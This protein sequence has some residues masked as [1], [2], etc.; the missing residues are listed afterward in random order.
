MTRDVKWWEPR[1]GLAQVRGTHQLNIMDKHTRVV[2]IFEGV[3]ALVG[4]GW[5]YKTKD[6]WFATPWSRSDK[7]GFWMG[8]EEGPFKTKAQA[9]AALG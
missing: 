8:P 5:V 7:D 2:R 9:L 6:G 3:Y 4:V 1:P